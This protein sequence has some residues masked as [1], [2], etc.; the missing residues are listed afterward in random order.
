[1]NYSEWEDFIHMKSCVYSVTKEHQAVVC[2]RILQAVGCLIPKDLLIFWASQGKWSHFK[3]WI[4]LISGDSFYWSLLPER[5][6]K[7]VLKSGEQFKKQGKQ[8]NIFSKSFNTP[9]ILLENREQMLLISS[10][11]V[12]FYISSV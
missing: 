9:F 12:H 4:H 11:L 10:Y 1:M 2:N 6:K 8:G 5:E 3:K 7:K